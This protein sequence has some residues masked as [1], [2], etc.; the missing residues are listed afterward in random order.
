MYWV[1]ILILIQIIKWMPLYWG[2]KAIP[3]PTLTLPDTI[4]NLLIYFLHFYWK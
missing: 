2:N 1:Q 4:F 3:S